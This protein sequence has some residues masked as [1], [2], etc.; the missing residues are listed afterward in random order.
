MVELSLDLRGNSWGY[1]LRDN[2]YAIR[3]SLREVSRVAKMM[4]CIGLGM[5]TGA[6]FIRDERLKKQFIAAGA[7]LI[8]TAVIISG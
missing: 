7:N 2:I 5:C 6:L 4:F 1:Q 8:L 3:E